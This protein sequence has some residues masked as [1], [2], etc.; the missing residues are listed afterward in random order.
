MM[1]CL[2]RAADGHTDAGRSLVAWVYLD[3]TGT[4]RDPEAYTLFAS[5][6]GP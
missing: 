6:F 3:P 1:A 5:F 4:A 2:Q